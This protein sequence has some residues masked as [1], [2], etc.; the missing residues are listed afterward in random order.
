MGIKLNKF[1][2]PFFFKSKEQAL[3]VSG[4]IRCQYLEPFK[5]KVCLIFSIFIEIKYLSNIYGVDF[6]SFFSFYLDTYLCIYFHFIFLVS[7]I[8]GMRDIASIY[9]YFIFLVSLITN[10]YERHCEPPCKSVLLKL[11]VNFTM[12]LSYR[13]LHSV[14]NTTSVKFSTRYGPGW[15]R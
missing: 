11:K 6:L 3:F 5:F 13:K 8:I 12:N 4:P 1:L 7:L 14:K 2:K 9:F 10:R 15:N